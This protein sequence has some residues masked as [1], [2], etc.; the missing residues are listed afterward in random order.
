MSSQLIP[1]LPDDPV[2]GRLLRLAASCPRCGSRPA[3]R[4]APEVVDAVAAHPAHA[5]LATYQC[6]RR[7]CGAIFDLTARAF[8]QA[9]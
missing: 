6:Q 9:S 4:V 5:R 1:A 8:Q 7:R 2:P 3:V